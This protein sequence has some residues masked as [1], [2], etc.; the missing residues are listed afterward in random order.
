MI[1]WANSIIILFLVLP[2]G[3]AFQVFYKRQQNYAN[4]PSHHLHQVITGKTTTTKRWLVPPW[5]RVKHHLHN[6]YTRLAATASND[7]D[8]EHSGDDVISIDETTVQDLRSFATQRC[9]QSF[10][11]LLASTRDLHTVKWLDTF[12]QP[13]TLNNYWEEDEVS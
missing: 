6:Q 1:A 8:D 9:I 5:I 4:A 2:E 3:S 7:D 10:M 12:V 13:I 11:F